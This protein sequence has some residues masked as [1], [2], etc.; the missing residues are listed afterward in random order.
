MEAE[1]LQVRSEGEVNVS[2]STRGPANASTTRRY[3]ETSSTDSHSPRQVDCETR[4]LR[5][6]EME[7]SGLI[8]LVRL[9]NA[10]LPARRIDL[11]CLIAGTDL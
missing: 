6:K 2:V 11:P 10:C 5:E 1:A 3:C 9:D 7:N 4:L 8:Q